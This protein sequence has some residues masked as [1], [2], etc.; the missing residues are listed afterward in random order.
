MRDL[1]K[2]F[3]FAMIVQVMMGVS[4]W[5]DPVKP[6][7][8]DVPM[9][10]GV[11]LATDVYLPGDE[12]EKY[13]AILILTPYGR[14]AAKGM[15][16]QFVPQGYVVVS[17]DIRG[18]GESE[19]SNVV[20]FQAGGWADKRDGH[21]TLNWISKQPWSNGKVATWGGSAVGITQN[22]LAPEAPDVLKA[23]YVE[24]AA[25][26]LYSQCMY[27]GGAIRKS[28]IESWLAAT[29]MTKGNL[30]IFRDH[31]AYDE[32]WE[33]LNPEAVADRT[34]APGIFV[35]GWYDIFCQGTI[36]SFVSMQSK[37][38]PRVRGNCRLIMGPWAH[39]GFKELKYPENSNKRPP[40]ADFKRYVD[41]HLKGEANGVD[42]DAPVHYYVMGDPNSPGA[43][44]NVWRSAES[45]PPAAKL[46]AFHFHA[47]GSLKTEEPSGD[48][49]KEYDFDP[50]NPV[51]TV[52]GQNLMLEK[53]PMDQRRIEDRN[54]VLVFTTDV[55]NEPLEVTGQIIAKLHVSSDAPDTD[56]TVKMSD[57]YPD[58]RSMLVTDGILRARYRNSFRKPE[59]MTPGEVYPIEVDLWSTSIIF[60]KGHRIRVV[61]SS[62]NFPRFDANPN[63]GK[64]YW[65]QGEKRIAH[66]TIHL[67]SKH[68]SHIVV[69][70][71]EMAPET[72]KS[73]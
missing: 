20:I 64:N 5:G 31:P 10:D 72:V 43:P 36:N 68:P 45:W 24:V 41:F 3:C 73:E 19:G 35:G 59:F 54:D 25:S 21:F 57:V 32:F 2:H 1:K 7:R 48:A 51:P 61:V 66:N 70:I 52:G 26:N 50:K 40:A 18:R 9:V 46:T 53:G 38:G 29:N 8:H 58:G 56:F 16:E 23:Q 67:S 42:K 30:Q 55:L 6:V 69:P 71:I 47:D 15:A 4:A 49:K 63:T 44:G 12:K 28:M 37:G 11:H 62:S 17:Q 22:M 60:N 33:T 34:I 39:G 27:E 65:E 14:G 13:P